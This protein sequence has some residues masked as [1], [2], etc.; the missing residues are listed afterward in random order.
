MQCRILPVEFNICNNPALTNVLLS[1]RLYL[2][3]L[4]IWKSI[5]RIKVFISNS[6]S[7]S[8][9]FNLDWY[10]TKLK[11]EHIKFTIAHRFLPFWNSCALSAGVNFCNTCSTLTKNMCFIDN[12]GNPRYSRRLIK[13]TQ[14]TKKASINER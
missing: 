2:T 4:E 9:V 12:S 5:S 10:P 6:Y 3:L 7:V 14:L 1:L 8:D 11:I 13:H